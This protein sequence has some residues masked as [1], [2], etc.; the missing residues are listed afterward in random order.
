LEE[1]GNLLQPMDRGLKTDCGCG[2]FAQRQVGLTSILEEGFLLLLT[3]LLYR[4]I[5][6]LNPTKTSGN[7]N[8]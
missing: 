6:G 5:G 7:H 2:L 3:G 1:G 8:G 4:V